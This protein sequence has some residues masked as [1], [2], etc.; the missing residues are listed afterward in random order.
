MARKSEQRTN[1]VVGMFVLVTGTMLLL[2][3]FIIATS[4]G[5]LERKVL[6]YSDFRTV[7]G[8][9]E[10]S[11]VQLGGKK[12]G[13]VKEVN[14]TS[15]T[16]PCNPEGEDLPGPNGNLISDD[17][18]STMFCAAEGTCAELVSYSGSDSSYEPCA[19]DGS[20]EL[21]ATV[22]VTKA[23]GERY[24]RVRWV[25]PEGKCAPYQTGLPR[26]SV[27]MEI[28][29]KQL[30]YIRKD[31]R[32]TISSNGVLGDQLININVG[33]GE[34][35]PPGGRLQ[36][37]PSLVEDIE[38]FKGRLEAIVDKIDDSLAGV[39]GLFDSLNDDRTKRDL[40][41]II[42]NANE[43]TR[44]IKDGDGAV[45]ALF[46]DP[47]YKKEF[48]AT[49][50]SLRHS[51][52]E[53]DSAMT[54]VNREV[55]PALRNISDAA[56]AADTM[57]DSVNDPDNPALI[58]RLFHDKELADDAKQAV[59]NTSE[60]I[61]AAKGAISD[62]QVLVAEV[63]HSIS[64]GEGTIGKLI[65]DP[66]AYDDLVKLLG[67]IERNNVIKT[68]VRFVVEQDEAAEP[69]APANSPP[70]LQPAANGDQ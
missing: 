44:Q 58:A 2:S 17:C 5:L 20:C 7:T 63:R 13:V 6:I 38:F 62:V 18:D 29:S 25:G 67:N 14:F 35:L 64:T 40:K 57:L 37:T 51:A 46:N 22:C 36:S 54:S 30:S 42:S 27:A 24:Q 11:P 10:G 41:G 55:T 61:A 34:A 60:S 1:F 4:E 21:E 3:L 28:S 43:I 9:G 23:F 70:P 68:M 39:S 49:L 19:P 47:E 31:S 15:P 48:G 52:G 66:K 69:G 50:R 59:E 56:D 26:V 32:A 65:K 53:F 45:G 16:Y 33:R 8:L 12:I